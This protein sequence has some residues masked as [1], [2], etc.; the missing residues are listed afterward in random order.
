MIIKGGKLSRVMVCGLTLM[1]WLGG[2][3]NVNVSSGAGVRQN[4]QRNQSESGRRES[5]EAES[6][7]RESE[8]AESSRRESEEADSRKSEETEKEEAGTNGE[9]GKKP[10]KTHPEPVS[11]S[12]VP[13]FRDDSGSNTQLVDGW[14]Y[15][16]WSRQLCR[17]NADTLESE[18]LFETVS[19]QVGLFS[20]Y[21]D[22]IYFVEQRNVSYLEGEKANLWRMKCDGT[23]QELI[24]EGFDVAEN[25]ITDMEIYDDILYL[26][27]WSADEEGNRYFRL[28]EDGSVEEISG[29]ETL[30]GMVPEGYGDARR[31]YRFG[32]LPNLVYCVRNFGYAF[33]CD[34]SGDLYRIILET[35]EAER[36]PLQNIISTMNGVTLTNE[37]L[38]YK[39]FS[40]IWHSVSLDDPEKITEIGEMDC[41]DIYDIAFWDEKGIYNIERNY[42]EDSFSVERLN[43]NGKKETLD[44]FVRNPRLRSSVYGDS[45]TVLYSDGDY[46]YYDSLSDG[47]GVICRIPLE[48]DDEEAEQVFVYYENPVVKLS[49]RETFDTTFTV[50][51]TGCQGEFTMTKVYLTE[52]TEAAA[53]INAFLEEQYRSEEEYIAGLMDLVRN[54]DSAEWENSRY[55]TLVEDELS[56]SIGY[57]DDNYIGFSMYWY[58]YWSG[59]AHGLHGSVEYVFSR[60]TG[61]RLLL[62]DIVA[63]SAEEICA[64]I[65]PYVEAKADWGTDE[66]GWEQIILEEGRFYLAAE[67]IG[68]HFDV[69]ELT[70]YASGGLDVVVPYELF[71][72]R[73][74]DEVGLTRF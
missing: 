19:P 48:G 32:K 58:E 64:I 22:T 7:R 2:C 30:Y 47:D 62:T 39:D 60:S 24:A 8:E 23:R 31:N 46:L 28:E 53:R 3:G 65:A 11:L 38:I 26:L 41:Y 14:I 29:A 21:G 50:E 6:S 51:A 68:I 4:G 72:M 20:I 55:M 10:Q 59:A 18:V 56:V 71:D 13:Y 74:P 16:Y 66:E 45:L 49:T 34:E 5:E 35:G 1:L 43:W 73:N 57:L 54:V 70:S 12:S 69:Y 67:G 9:T 37:A 63:N 17:V 42:W 61:E 36:I 44:Y 25:T 33:L 15:G 27:S 40:D 52:E